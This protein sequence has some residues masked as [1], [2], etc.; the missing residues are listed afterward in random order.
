[1]A[2]LGVGSFPGDPESLEQELPLWLF[3]VLLLG[4]A[5]LGDVVKSVINFLPSL[6]NSLGGAGGDNSACR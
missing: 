3:L 5:E 1:M 4:L 6:A 2:S